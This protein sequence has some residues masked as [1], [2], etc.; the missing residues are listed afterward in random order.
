MASPTY[1][2]N[3]KM[4]TKPQAMLLADGYTSA[5]GFYVP[6]GVEYE[7]FI[8]LSDANRKEIDVKLERIEN[9]KRMVNGRM[10]G[11]HI[12]DKRTYSTSWN[13]LPSRPFAVAPEFNTSGI[14][15]VPSTDYVADHGAGGQTIKDWYDTHPGEF[16]LLLSY[17]AVTYG[18]SAG[19]VEA[20]RVS[21]ADFQYSIVK[22]G[23][24][25]FWD[26]SLALEEA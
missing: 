15:T 1:L 11:Y 7:D 13:M 22:R 19:Y 2:A 14:A 8:I 16:W 24:V 6:D 23:V 20:V 9:K 26:V 3:R 10:R 21:C 18:S 25:D 12:A 5:S 17:D 4:Y